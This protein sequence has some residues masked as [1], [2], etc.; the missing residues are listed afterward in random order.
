MN[1]RYLLLV[2]T[3]L[4]CACAAA[5]LFRP[6]QPRAVAQEPTKAGSKWEYATI[7][8]YGNG[9][10]VAFLKPNEELRAE[11]WQDLAGKMKVPLSSTTGPGFPDLR[12]ALLNHLGGQGWELVSH[13]I[14]PQPGAPGTPVGH[15]ELYTFKRRAP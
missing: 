2:A 13:S 5:L 4:G 15:Y 7:A 14:V 11:T 8:H 9:K 6:E 10:L 3:A 1:R 12:V